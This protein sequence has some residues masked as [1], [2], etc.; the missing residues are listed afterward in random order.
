MK[1]L[2]RILLMVSVTA[3]LAGCKLAVI[4]VEGGEVQSDGSGTCVASSICIVGVSEPG[5]AETFTAIPEGG[6]YFHKWN[7]GDGFFCGGS[8]NPA[9]TLSFQGYEESKEAEDMVASSET[10]YLMPVFSKVANPITDTVTVDGREWAQVDLFTNLS[11]YQI[12]AV[13]P[14]GI[15][16][17]VLNGHDMTGWIWASVDDINVL[18][19]HYIGSDEMGP[20]P[21]VFFYKSSVS[22]WTTAFFND[23]WRP[24]LL[25]LAGWERAIE[26]W[27]RDMSD[28]GLVS[29]G[30]I[31]DGEKEVDVGWE[32]YPGEMAETSSYEAPPNP[33]VEEGLP[34]VGGWF[35][36]SP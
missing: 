15:C 9:C 24:T 10:Y 35:Y 23:G 12:S 11:W 13:C 34:P 17:G 7:S 14:S 16:V 28:Q 27:A 33:D 21:D 6:W 8:T 4:V 30:R 31:L 2:V 5:F 3:L 20:G 1:Q 19:N 18:F 26:G 22:P 36:R 29:F 32:E 25:D